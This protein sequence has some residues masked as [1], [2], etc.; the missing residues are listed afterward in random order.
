MF[1]T[2]RALNWLKPTM[3]NAGASQNRDAP[4]LLLPWLSSSPT[5]IF[6]FF[7]T[8]TALPVRAIAYLIGKIDYGFLWRIGHTPA[9]PPSGK[10]I[11][12]P[13][14]GVRIAQQHTLVFMPAAISQY[15]GKSACFG[16]VVILTQSSAFPHRNRADNFISKFVH[17]FIPPKLLSQALC[18]FALLLFVLLHQFLS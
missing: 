11:M 7:D 5:D 13:V 14:I 8:K 2:L 6:F 17:S 12:I 16:W 1:R 9:L 4:A 18:L 3:T 15:L 10:D